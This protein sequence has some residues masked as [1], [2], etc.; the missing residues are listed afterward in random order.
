M[1]VRSLPALEGGKHFYFRRPFAPL[2]V[3]GLPGIDI[4]TNSGYVVSPPSLHPDTGQPYRW[5]Q[6]S[7]P[8]PM[9]LWL[10][11]VLTP[12]PAAPAAAT[13]L[14]GV[15]SGDSIADA[16]GAATSWRDLL[17]RH[18]WQLVT[19]DGDSD[20]SCWRHPRATAAVSATVKHGCLFVYSP[21]TPFPVTE[22][23]RPAGITRFRALA[24]LD[25]HG[26]LS[27][28]ARAVREVVR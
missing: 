21:N 12:T 28:A 1:V 9:P 23:E 13:T 24:I 17:P 16:Y 14:R 22:T 18:G 8:A 6:T 19:G 3:K 26:D 4:K 11:Q 20:G 2:S 15:Y 5:E 7:E 27:A 25:H 10:Q